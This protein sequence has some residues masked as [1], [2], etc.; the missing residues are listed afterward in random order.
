MWQKIFPFVSFLPTLTNSGA[1]YLKWPDQQAVSPARVQVV[2]P[3]AQTISS[4]PLTS[5]WEEDQI[6]SVWCSL[7][8]NTHPIKELLVFRLG[9]MCGGHL[10]MFVLILLRLMWSFF[11]VTWTVICYLHIHPQHTQWHKCTFTSMYPLFSLSIPL[12]PTPDHVSFISRPS[13]HHTIL[14]HNRDRS[15]SFDKHVT[16]APVKAVPPFSINVSSLLITRTW[17]GLR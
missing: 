10:F 11:N 9:G 17:T 5:Y 2:V 4:L 12:G 13:L 15:R 14:I 7:P 6:T 3:Q 16:S 8:A 1:K